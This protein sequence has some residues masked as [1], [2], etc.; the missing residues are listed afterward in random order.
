MP[1]FS[2][3][4]VPRSAFAAAMDRIGWNRL[5]TI[6]PG[7]KDRAKTLRELIDDLGGGTYSGRPVRAVQVGQKAMASA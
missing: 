1:G 5:E 4:E 6:M 3:N 2:P 7:L